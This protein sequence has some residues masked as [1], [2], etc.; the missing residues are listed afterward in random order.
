MPPLSEFRNTPLPPTKLSESTLSLQFSPDL[1]LPKLSGTK[2]CL[3]PWEYIITHFNTYQFIWV[4][5][6]ISS[7]TRNILSQNMLHFGRES[8]GLCHSYQAPWPV[9]ILPDAFNAR[10]ARWDM[11]IH[12]MKGKA[13]RCILRSNIL[14]IVSLVISLIVLFIRKV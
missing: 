2:L 12:R 6:I 11:P 4:L 8:V 5:S 13:K 14:D 1:A 7:K 3:T 9:D 10:G